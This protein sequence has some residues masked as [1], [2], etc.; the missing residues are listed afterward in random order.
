[1]VVL[2][3]LIEARFEG[4]EED[5]LEGCSISMTGLEDAGSMGALCNR[6][7]AFVSASK[8]GGGGEE[9]GEKDRARGRLADCFLGGNHLLRL[10]LSSSRAGSRVGG[11]NTD[12]V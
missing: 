6:R 9:G 5:G 3:L 8:K 12:R 10:G 2:L 11:S 7:S 4:G 1:M